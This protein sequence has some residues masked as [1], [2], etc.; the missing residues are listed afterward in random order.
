VFKFTIKRILMMI[1]V[2]LGII[3]IVFTIMALAPGD[4]ARL[5]LGEKASQEQVN[6][7]REQMGLNDPFFVRYAR[8]TINI[9]KGD[10]GRSYITNVPVHEIIFARFPNT[11]KLAVS[12]M[13]LSVLIGMPIGILSAI[14]QYTIVDAASMI[15]ALLATSIPGFW[16]G[17]MLIIVFSLNLRWFPSFGFIGIK[18]MVLPSITLATVNAALIIRL[19][20]SSMLEVIKQDYIRTARAKGATERRVIFRHALKNSLLPVITVIGVNFGTLLGGAVVTETVFGIPGLGTAIVN[21][22]RMR[23]N[24]VILASVVFI[25]VALSMVNLFVDIMYTFIDPRLRPR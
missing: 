17:L 20:R 15:F 21:A 13:F 12:G 22:I 11:A 6:T 9:F 23:D 8:Y 4:P 5:I 7:L 14:K 18:Y 19:T 25:A 16:L 10:F 2:I 24:P 3:F 1:P